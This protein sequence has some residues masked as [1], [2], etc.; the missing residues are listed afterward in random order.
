VSISAGEKTFGKGNA[1]RESFSV[2]ARN[3]YGPRF[4]TR[5]VIKYLQPKISKPE[6]KE[7]G[8]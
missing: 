5:E 1:K 7:I 8:R 4:T 6:E 2:E 3:Q